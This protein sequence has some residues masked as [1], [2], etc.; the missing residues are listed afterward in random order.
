MQY[1]GLGK[2]KTDYPSRRGLTF[3][4]NTL[5][6]KHSGIY[7]LMKLKDSGSLSKDDIQEF[8][9][10]QVQSPR[11]LSGF[12]ELCYDLNLSLQSF[13][14]QIVASDLKAAGISTKNPIDVSIK[15]IKSSSV[16]AQLLTQEFDN[17][18]EGGYF[19]RFGDPD[20]AFQK[21]I[22]NAW[23]D[24]EAYVE[25]SR[26]RKDFDEAKARAKAKDW[27]RR[28]KEG[29]AKGKGLSQIFGKYETGDRQYIRD[30]TKFV[31]EEVPH[32]DS[33][34]TLVVDDFITAGTTLNSMEH[35]VRNYVDR[36]EPSFVYKVALFSK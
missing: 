3:T 33:I 12:D 28:L 20:V 23:F 35:N 1:Q 26:K 22:T 27:S 16:I 7:S 19:F 29:L 14:R 21:D 5:F 31:R 15:L 6:Q 34:V 11:S 32:F 17:T 2:A 4:S 8:F 13:L 36:N 18:Q 10:R 25:E 30:L 9:K 24:E